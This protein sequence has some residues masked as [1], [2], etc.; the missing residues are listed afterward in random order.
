MLHLSTT[1][2]DSILSSFARTA[3]TVEHLRRFCTAM[4]KT[5]SKADSSPTDTLSFTVSRRN[6]RTFEAFSEAVDKLVRDFDLWCATQEEE[7]CMA[8]AG[9][10]PPRIISLLDLE[11]SLRDRFSQTFDVLLTILHTAVQRAT[12]SPEPIAAIWTFPDLPKRMPPAASTA[13]LLDALLHSA[14][15]HAA[16]GDSPTAAALLA[17]FAAAAAPLWGTVR[18]W[19]ADG[20]P[21][22]DHTAL[23]GAGPGPTGLGDEF[24]VEDNELPLLDPDFWADGFVLRGAVEADGAAGEAG[25]P[26]FLRAS[27]PLVL[28]AGKAV[29]LLHA[30]GMP[31]GEGAAGQGR[32]MDRWR[33]L[34]E[35]LESARLERETAASGRT[36]TWMAADDFAR[37]VY[38]ELHAPCVA[39]QATLTRVL[40]E[41]CELWVHLSAIEEVYLMRRGDVMTAFLDVLFTRVRLLDLGRK[42]V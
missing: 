8:R 2:Q 23:A 15:D 14:Q 27:A 26:A 38:E 22:R 30:L 5:A 34:G 16:Q 28:A 33:G 17:V 3:T 6:T 20:M 35:L 12:H 24:F 29:G 9:L 41:E 18:R 19:L 11:K 13:Q 10:G 36:G 40:V 7:I 21:I 32:W 4:F 37:L 39:A 42:S 31:M 25:V 1:A